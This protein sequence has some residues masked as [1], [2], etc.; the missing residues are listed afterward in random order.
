MQLE[1]QAYKDEAPYST[2]RSNLWPMLMTF[3]IGR[4]LASMRGFQLLEEASKEVG[5]VINK[6]KTKLYGSS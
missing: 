1:N 5:L 6:G 4:S 2:S 3:I